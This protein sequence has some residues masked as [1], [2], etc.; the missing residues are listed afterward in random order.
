YVAETVEGGAADKAGVLP[1]DVIIAVEGRPIRSSASLQERIAS[2]RP[3]DEV[4]ITLWRDGASIEKTITLR[5]KDNEMGLVAKSSEKVESLGISI[6]TLDED[7]LKKYNVKYGIKV[8]QVH[9]GVVSKSTD[10]RQG[11]V[12]TML[13]DQPIKSVEDF[14]DAIENAEG[15]VILEGKYQDSERT[16]LKAF[17]FEQ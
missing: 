7:D 2:F 6:A 3:G 11:F 1:G 12:V 15:R 17:T 9:P 14:N 10:I 4:N 8:T 16:Y 5:N 13:N